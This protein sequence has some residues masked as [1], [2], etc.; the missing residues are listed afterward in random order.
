MDLGSGK[1]YLSQCLALQYGLKV[2]GVDSSNDNAQYAARRNERLLK[3]WAGLVRKSQ[4]DDAN[5]SSSFPEKNITCTSGHLKSQPSGTVPL[6]QK[7][8]TCI[9]TDNAQ[10]VKSQESH[11]HANSANPTSFVPVTR[12]VDQSFVANGDLTRLF[13]ELESSSD[14][15][16][17]TCNGMF[18]V[19]LHTCGDLAPTALRIF[20]NEPSV[21]LICIVGCCYHLVTQEIGGEEKC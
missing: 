12:F 14:K 4:R 1:G 7:R 6:A 20:E 2:V 10:I 5:S 3:V 16:N 9:Y 21:K 11:T 18:I 15:V 8:H 13:D 17:T 19:G